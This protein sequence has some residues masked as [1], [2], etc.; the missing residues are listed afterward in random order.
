[1]NRKQGNTKNVKVL[2]RSKHYIPLGDN[3]FRMK[4]VKDVPSSKQHI[5]E[6]RNMWD[7]K[8]NINSYLLPSTHFYSIIKGKIE[9]ITSYKST[10]GLKEGKSTIVTQKPM[11]SQREQYRSTVHLFIDTG[12]SPC[13]ITLMPFTFAN[14]SIVIHRGLDSLFPFKSVSF[15]VIM[16]KLPYTALALFHP[17]YPLRFFTL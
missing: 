1:M 16:P 9:I 10:F 13:K 7:I 4:V 6:E 12:R 3:D 11:P 14:N 8:D 17:L 5:N 2:H 15:Y